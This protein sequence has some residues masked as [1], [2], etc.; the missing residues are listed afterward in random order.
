MYKFALS[1]GLHD[2]AQSF[3]GYVETRSCRLAGDP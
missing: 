3:I 1:M 2:P